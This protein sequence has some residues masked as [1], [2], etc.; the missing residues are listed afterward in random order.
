MI[1][2]EREFR[3]YMLNE[4]SDGGP[5]KLSLSTSSKFEV[6]EEIAT[7]MRMAKKLSH[8]E[9]AKDDA[10]TAYEQ[11]MSLRIRQYSA[12]RQEAIRQAEEF[13]QGVTL[14]PLRG[15]DYFVED[16]STAASS[17]PVRLGSQ[18]GAGAS[19]YFD[20]ASSMA[21]PGTTQGS[22][23][24]DGSCPPVYLDPNFDPEAPN[25]S[26]CSVLYDHARRQQHRKADAAK[27][28][29]RKGRNAARNTEV[30]DAIR[31]YDDDNFGDSVATGTGGDG[32]EGDDDSITDSIG[33]SADKAE[34]EHFPLP[35]MSDTL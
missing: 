29:G 25:R 16:G 31:R 1:E 28:K 26:A 20:S 23:C 18:E 32:G 11:E 22:S 34:E 7:R 5:K 19:R 8:F 15:E 3:R 30:S 12:T 9:Q 2:E 14:N 21:F 13:G 4:G 6:P 35:A 10:L 17:H 24:Y 27:K 33:S